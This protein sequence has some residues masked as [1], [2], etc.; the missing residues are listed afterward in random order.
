MGKH[1]WPQNKLLEMINALEWLACVPAD[2]EQALVYRGCD[3]LA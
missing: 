2:I 3:I 1:F